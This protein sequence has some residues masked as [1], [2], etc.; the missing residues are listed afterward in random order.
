MLPLTLFLA[1]GMVLLP[2][3]SSICTTDDTLK[4]MY[5]KG[6]LLVI[7]DNGREIHV[8]KLPND[9]F[10]IKVVNCNGNFNPFNPIIP[11]GEGGGA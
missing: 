7:C 8:E 9:S 2:N 10:F 3:V 1:V 5:T 6:D 11:G 4:L